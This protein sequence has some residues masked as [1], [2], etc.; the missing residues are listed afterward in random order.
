MNEP[1]RPWCPLTGGERPSVRWVS[2]VEGQH[3]C[4]LSFLDH[5][6]VLT[7]SFISRAE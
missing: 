1:Y 6:V 4:Y 7:P 3:E 2:D 5:R